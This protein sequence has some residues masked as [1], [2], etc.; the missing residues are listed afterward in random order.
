MIH[1]Q[2]ATGSQFTKKEILTQPITTDGVN[3]DGDA[4]S[5]QPDACETQAG[6]ME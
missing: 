6:F 5:K 1:M 3:K 2:S 4:P